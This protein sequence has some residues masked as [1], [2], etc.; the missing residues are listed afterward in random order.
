MKTNIN[1]VDIRRLRF[2]SICFVAA[3]AISIF[4]FVSGHSV[5][6]LPKDA[7]TTFILFSIATFALAMFTIVG[8]RK[9]VSIRNKGVLLPVFMWL[10]VLAII[11]ILRTT[12]LAFFA[13]SSVSLAAT[14]AYF[15]FKK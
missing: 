7:G 15:A 4:L 3:T 5:A 11:G 1:Q 8:T 10:L 2:F 6:L 12:S 13:I 14:S 9:H